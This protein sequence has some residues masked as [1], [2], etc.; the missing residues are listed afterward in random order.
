MKHQTKVLVN[1]QGDA[2]YGVILDGDAEVDDPLDLLEEQ[3]LGSY[4]KTTWIAKLVP[5]YVDDTG[6]IYPPI[7]WNNELLYDAYPIIAKG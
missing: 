4:H 1:V 7:D 3:F 6:N 5:C 2:N